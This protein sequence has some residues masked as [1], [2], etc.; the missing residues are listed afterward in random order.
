MSAYRKPHTTVRELAQRADDDDFKESFFFWC[1][2]RGKSG[3]FA[4]LAT[5]VTNVWPAIKR[6][7][8]LARERP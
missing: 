3:D 6:E 7:R 1:D 8:R 2:V 4:D 5:F